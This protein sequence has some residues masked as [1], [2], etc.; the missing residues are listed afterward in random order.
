MWA[1]E[2]KKDNFWDEVSTALPHRTRASVYKHVRRVYHT[3]EQRGKW[4][5][6]EDNEL[7]HFVEEFGMSWKT[8]GVH[9]GRMP[10][11]CR[12]R[13]RNYVK[14]GQNRGQNKWSLEEEN[15]LLQVV[16]E[17]KQFD[18]SADINWTVVSEKIGGVRSR[19]QCRYKWNKIQ[20]K[21]A[22]TMRNSNVHARSIAG[23]PGEMHL[24]ATVDV[25]GGIVG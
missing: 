13:W 15:K 25:T 11:D 24:D 19:I 1:N 2:R 8:I 3:Y 14:C 22:A 18:P 16:N 9:I 17:I 7:R 21:N 12:D 6:E 5:A 23:I 20:K 4:T 10:E